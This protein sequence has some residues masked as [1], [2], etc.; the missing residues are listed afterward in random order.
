M[1]WHCS[2]LPALLGHSLC[3]LF[4]QQGERRARVKREGWCPQELGTLE[5]TLDPRSL[6][7]PSSKQSA[8]PL[9]TRDQRPR[10]NHSGVCTEPHHPGKG[11]LSWGVLGTKRVPPKTCPSSFLTRW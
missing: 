9:G 11:Q 6:L 7:C 1:R 5:P 8:V 2:L 10:Q 3:S 4:S